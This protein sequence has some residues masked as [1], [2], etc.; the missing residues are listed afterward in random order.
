MSIKIGKSDKYWNI[1]D[2]FWLRLDF[3]NIDFFFFNINIIT[4]NDIA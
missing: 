4:K 1:F 2:W 3:D